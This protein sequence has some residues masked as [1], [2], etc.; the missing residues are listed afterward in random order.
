MRNFAPH[1]VPRAA[2]NA[3]EVKVLIAVHW[4]ITIFSGQGILELAALAEVKR[5]TW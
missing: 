4:R 5:G 2:R 1:T 3:V